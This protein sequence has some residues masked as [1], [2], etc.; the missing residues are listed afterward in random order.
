MIM[1]ARR[2]EFHLI[3]NILLSHL[4]LWYGGSSGSEYFLVYNIGQPISVTSDRS[5][6]LDISTQ[7]E[8]EAYQPNARFPSSIS[9]WENKY[10]LPRSSS[11]QL[12]V[13]EDL[14]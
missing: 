2:V 9:T 5:I 3:S 6:I 14:D 1:I 13:A 7:D 11:Q 4:I 10:E 8:L 12:V